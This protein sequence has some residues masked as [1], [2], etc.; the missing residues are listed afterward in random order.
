[1]QLIKPEA[2]KLKMA[3]VLELF[4]AQQTFG[5]YAKVEGDKTVTIPY[6]IGGLTRL[7][8]GLN[9]KDLRSIVEEYQSAV[10]ALREQHIGSKELSQ[11]LVDAFNKEVQTLL[12]AETEVKQRKIKL[13]DLNPTENPFDPNL[14]AA[15]DP[16]LVYDD[17]S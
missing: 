8:I 5:G 1:M 12:D 10:K 13:A 17:A 11:P 7:A 4:Q 14:Y 15:L 6:S 9:V 3:L 2:I 16:I